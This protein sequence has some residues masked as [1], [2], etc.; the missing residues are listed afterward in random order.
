MSPTLPK[1]I[2]AFLKSKPPLSVELFLLFYNYYVSIGADYIETTKT[3]V[4]FGKKRYCYIY[5]FSKPFIS[6]VLRL[7]E[8][9]EDPDL[10]FKTGKVSSTTYVH[11]FRLYEQSDLNAALK[12]Y[13]KLALN[14]DYDNQILT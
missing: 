8:L 4:A 12:K 13:M 6:G 7:N 3:T 1:D 11:H 9:H 14:G 2:A 5:Q 10:F